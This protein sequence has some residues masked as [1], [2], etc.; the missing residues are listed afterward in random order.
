VVLWSR[1]RA[2]GRG[3]TLVK[4]L[5]QAEKLGRRWPG[6]VAR[7]CELCFFG[8]GEKLPWGREEGP[9]YGA[10]SPGGRGTTP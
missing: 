4:V 6:A 10:R 3:R 1:A 7:G 2:K 8:D 9:F 5:V